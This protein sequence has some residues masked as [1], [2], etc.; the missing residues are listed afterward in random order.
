[1]SLKAQIN[2]DLKQALLS[3]DKQKAT[4]LR[5]LKSVILNEEIRLGERE[6]GLGEDAVIQ[7]LQKE[8][9]KRQEAIDLY[10]QAGSA[11]RAEQEGA[12]KMI[13]DAYLPEQMSE[14]QI[15]QLVDAALAK[16]NEVSPALMGKIIGAVKAEAGVTADGAVIARIVKEK[17]QKG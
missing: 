11:D 2:N 10:T 17:L 9:K 1:M 4:T 16:E 12:E 5:G 7:C 6:S 3:G 14:G 13:I 15:E 8:S